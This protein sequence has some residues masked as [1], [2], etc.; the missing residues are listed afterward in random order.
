MT[1]TNTEAAVKTEE[2]GIQ[3]GAISSGSG[4]NESVVRGPA[5]DSGRVAL[6]Q[7]SCIE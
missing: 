6:P 4:W 1:R 5:D 7:G 2:G 3:L